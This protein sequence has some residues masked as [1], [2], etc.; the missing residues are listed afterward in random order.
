[1]ILSSGEGP[2]DVRALRGSANRQLGILS[3]ILD[4]PPASNPKG[5]QALSSRL[6]FNQMTHISVCQ[7]VST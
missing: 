7:V 2:E 4:C 5:P 3:P 6:D 1:M